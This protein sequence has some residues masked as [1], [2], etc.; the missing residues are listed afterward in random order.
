MQNAHSIKFIVLKRAVIHSNPLFCLAVVNARPQLV[1]LRIQDLRA[2]AVANKHEYSK[3]NMHKFFR[4]FDDSNDHLISPAE[5]QE[6]L[7]HM[8][9]PYTDNPAITAMMFEEI[10][11]LQTG[12]ISEGGHFV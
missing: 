12:Y 6:A 8:G 5:F 3:V 10:D 7:Q 1:H 4:L 11:S 9:Y 2:I